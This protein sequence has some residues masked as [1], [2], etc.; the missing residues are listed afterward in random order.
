MHGDKLSLIGRCRSMTTVKVVCPV[1]KGRKKL[2]M[3][4]YP[5]VKGTSVSALGKVWVKCPE[6]ESNGS[7]RQKFI[8]HAHRTAMIFS[9]RKGT[10]H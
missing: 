1:C 4:K 5:H 10:A 9:K 2:L 8:K 3:E 7:W 6:C